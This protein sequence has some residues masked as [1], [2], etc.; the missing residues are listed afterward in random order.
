VYV[1][2][3]AG[4]ERVLKII[5]KMIMIK[6]KKKLIIIYPRTPPGTRLH[7]LTIPHKGLRFS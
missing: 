6:V 5:L 3:R 7:V 2:A 4:V 1:C